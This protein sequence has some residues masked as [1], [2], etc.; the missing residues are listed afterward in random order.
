MPWPHML[1]PLKTFSP[2]Y[3]S[4][5]PTCAAAALKVHDSPPPH[6]CVLQALNQQLNELAKVNLR[7]VAAA[8]ENEQQ[9]GKRFKGLVKRTCF[10]S[11]LSTAF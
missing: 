1:Q 6:T 2:C 8:K 3:V 5:L 10:G 7:Y 9:V 11:L 4:P